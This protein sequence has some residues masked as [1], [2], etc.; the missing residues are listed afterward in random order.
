MRLTQSRNSFQEAVENLF[1]SLN[2]QIF[3]LNQTSFNE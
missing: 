1:V 2:S 3:L